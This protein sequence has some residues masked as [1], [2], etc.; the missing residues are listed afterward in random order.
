MAPKKHTESTVVGE[1]LS[2]LESKGRDLKAGYT[3]SPAGWCKGND[4]PKA[5]GNYGKF[6]GRGWD[7]VG[8]NRTK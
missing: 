7:G 6:V 2:A 5:R 4:F 1:M 3:E 8:D